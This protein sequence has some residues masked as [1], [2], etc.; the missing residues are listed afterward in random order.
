M[1]GLS[2]G[3]VRQDEKVWVE[4]GERKGEKRCE[5]GRGGVRRVW[6]T[7]EGNGREGLGTGGGG[8]GGGGAFPPLGAPQPPPPFPPGR[9]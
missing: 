7:N 8:G 2:R 6:E 4:E 1:G 9:R 5:K 3:G